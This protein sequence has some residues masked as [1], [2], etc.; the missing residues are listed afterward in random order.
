MGKDKHPLVLL[1]EDNAGVLEGFKHLLLTNGYLVETAENG[2]A[3]LTLLHGGLRPDLIVLDL[4][5]PVM[6]G[7]EFRQHQ[8][9]HPELATIPVIV[10]SATT[11]AAANAI[12]LNATAYLQKPVGP[13]ALLEQL[14][15]LLPIAPR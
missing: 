3:A 2:Q 4:M 13:G 7:Y 1:V 5:M 14:R 8:M 6:S 9:K 12:H 11:D 10:Y 15:K